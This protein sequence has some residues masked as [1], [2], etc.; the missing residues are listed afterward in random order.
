VVQVVYRFDTDRGNYAALSRRNLRLLTGEGLGERAA[1]LTDLADRFDKPSYEAKAAA[2]ARLARQ[3][4]RTGGDVPSVAGV[5]DAFDSGQLVPVLGGRTPQMVITDVPYGEQT[6]WA[7]PAVGA[8][9]PGMARAV[10]SVVPAE[11]V[12]IVA[13][14]GRRVPLGDVVPPV[15]RFKVGTRSVAI[16]RAGQLRTVRPCGSASLRRV[17]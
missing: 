11:T 9:V 16:V 4:T 7:G 13:V 12:I 17:S 2:A 15:Q 14:R 3:L 10:A 6:D 1:E 5:A 8:G